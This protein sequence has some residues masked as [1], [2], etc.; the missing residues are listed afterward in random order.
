MSL[1]EDAETCLPACVQ[2]KPSE[3]KVD[4]CLEGWKMGLIKM[5]SLQGLVLFIIS[6]NRGRWR[7]SE[8]KNHVQ[9]YCL[10]FFF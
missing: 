6:E 4:F 1:S 10:D 2:L 7:L 9:Q 8:A 5:F 3:S